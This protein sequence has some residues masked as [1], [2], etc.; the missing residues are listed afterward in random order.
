LDTQSAKTLPDWTPYLVGGLFV[1][2]FACL[3]VWQLQ[4]GLEKRERQQLFAKDTGYASWSPG[5]DVAAFQRLKVTGRFD[6]A[7]QFLLENIVLNARP[8]YYVITPM[9]LGDGE[10]VLLVN[11]GWLPKGETLPGIEQLAVPSQSSTVR[12]RAGALPRAGMKMGDGI[13]PGQGWPRLAVFPDI[14][15]VAAELG[16]EVD[17]MVLLLDPEDDA[18]FVR[19][20]KPP[21][22]GPGRHFGYALQWFVMG[23]ALTW[24]LMRNYRR[25]GFERSD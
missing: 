5:M 14:D 4:R 9:L 20:W 1:L 2:L 12:G 16:R 6:D 22:F 15:E 19:N 21:E 25:R 8:G 23:A 17:S 3:C 10:P 18:G 11:R 24:L 13:A 7:H